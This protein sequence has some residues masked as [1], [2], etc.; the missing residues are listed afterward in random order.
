MFSQCLGY[1]YLTCYLAAY[2]YGNHICAKEI[3]GCV[4]HVYAQKNC[5]VF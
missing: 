4:Y 5:P 2:K 3:M 1:R